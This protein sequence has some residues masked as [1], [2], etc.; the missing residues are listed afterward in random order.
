M[1]KRKLEF[2]VLISIG[3]S[4]NKLS[5]S[6]FYELIIVALLGVILA[7]IITLPMYTI[8]LFI[9]YHLWRRGYNI[10]QFSIYSGLYMSLDFTLFIK[11]FLIVIGICLVFTAYPVAF[12]QHLKVDEGLS[13]RD[14]NEDNL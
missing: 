3:M 11:Q 6:L 4:R 7:V 10:K 8:S 5:K 1:T 12:I 2:S 14:A 13:K 9:L